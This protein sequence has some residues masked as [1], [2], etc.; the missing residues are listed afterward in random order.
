[1]DHD[2]GIRFDFSEAFAPESL[3]ERLR[4]LADIAEVDGLEADVFLN[5]KSSHPTW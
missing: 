5:S 4:R 3:S 1:M 2:H